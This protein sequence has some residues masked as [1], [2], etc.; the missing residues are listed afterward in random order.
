[1]NNYTRKMIVVDEVEAT[2]LASIMFQTLIEEDEQD[3]IKEVLNTPEKAR[4]A[5]DKLSDNPAIENMS[6]EEQ[7][8]KAKSLFRKL[9]YAVD[10]E[11][12]K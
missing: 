8:E 2:L 3:L 1:M 12:I 4:K 11:L 7:S 10:Y 6:P 9:L 5:I